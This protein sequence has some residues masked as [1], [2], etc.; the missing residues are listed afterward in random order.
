MS[1]DIF[2]G[3]EDLYRL[4][5]FILGNAA[6]TLLPILILTLS[7]LKKSTII[8]PR[9]KARQRKD[10][11]GDG[12]EIQPSLDIL[13]DDRADIGIEWVVPSKR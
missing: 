4:S 6:I 8:L 1:F 13:K 12:V 9:S 10:D 5:S 3:S 2:Q 11:G 7:A